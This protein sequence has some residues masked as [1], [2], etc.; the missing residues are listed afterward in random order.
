[1]EPADRHALVEEQSTSWLESMFAA[2]HRKV[3]AAAYRITGNGADAED[4]L[5]T[6]F[7]RLAG[8]GPGLD[9]AEAYLHRAAVNA[10]LDVL[11]GRREQLPLSDADGRAAGAGF[12]LR[13]CLRQA[14]SRLNPKA[15]EIFT[16]RHIEGWS[17]AEIA[18]ATGTS[19]AVIAVLLFRARMR[20][21][22]ELRSLTGGRP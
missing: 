2:N 15:A 17:N 18:R 7:L 9:N 11:R 20:L 4:V 5:Q 3:F 6:V 16:L 12:E 10:A 22:K 21:R 8:R 14:L 19:A 13:Q 1:M